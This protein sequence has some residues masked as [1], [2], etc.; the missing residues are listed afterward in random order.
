MGH[1][2]AAA[3]PGQP[4]VLA[5]TGRAAPAC[6][7]NNAGLRPA[8][9]VVLAGAEPIR[10]FRGS[11]CWQQSFRAVCADTPAPPELLKGHLP[12]VVPP[13]AT[14]HIRFDPPPQPGSIRVN[15]WEQGRPQPASAAVTAGRAAEV[16]LTLPTAPGPYLY[17]V[18][19]QW[20]QGDG[21][22]AFQVLVE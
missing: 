21:S 22:Y 2:A 7:N 15:R 18:S 3:A 9:S 17:D 16:T 8:R 1:L 20:P 5:G 12:P 4:R 13:G 11:Y 6:S 14:L 19:A 10:T